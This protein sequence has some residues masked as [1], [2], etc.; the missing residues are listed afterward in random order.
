MRIRTSLS[1]RPL[2]DYNI[3]DGDSLSSA[4]ATENLVIENIVNEI[5]NVSKMEPLFVWNELAFKK[6]KHFSE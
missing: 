2:I 4:T 6:A 5:N 3:L 1:R